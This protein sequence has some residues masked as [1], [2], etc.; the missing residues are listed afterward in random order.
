MLR[1]LRNALITGIVLLLPVSVT[2]FIVK[3]LVDG[4]GVPATDLFFWYLDPK[5]RDGQFVSPILNIISLLVVIVFIIGFGF[6]SRYVLGRTFLDLIEK[7]FD[8]VP[9]V[10]AV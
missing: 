5:I 3:F 6:L 8:R 10:N 4:I 9:F 7:S 1:Q 2:I